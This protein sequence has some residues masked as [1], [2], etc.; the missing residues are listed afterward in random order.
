VKAVDYQYASD[1]LQLS[2]PVPAWAE[3]Y[4]QS[5]CNGWDFPQFA[6]DDPRREFAVFIR[7]GFRLDECGFPFPDHDHWPLKLGGGLRYP[8]EPAAWSRKL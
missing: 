8:S 1:P 6:E 7:I 2:V 5:V 3:A 4:G